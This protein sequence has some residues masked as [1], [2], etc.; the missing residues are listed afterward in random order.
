MSEVQWRGA[1]H[2]LCA[3]VSGHRVLADV[4]ELRD[5]PAPGAQVTLHFA[6]E[7]AVLLLPTGTGDA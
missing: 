3:D 7:D 2:R 4:R 5:P 1:T 6:P